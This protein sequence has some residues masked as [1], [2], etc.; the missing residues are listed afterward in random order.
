MVF[1][2]LFNI[3]K[4]REC[5]AFVNST[6]PTWEGPEDVTGSSLHRAFAVTLANEQETAWFQQLAK[7]SHSLVQ[8]SSGMY[9]EEGYYH[10]ILSLNESLN[11]RVLF[12]IADFED[13]SV[14]PL[15]E[16][17]GGVFEETG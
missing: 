13:H 11:E 3:D 10:I 7:V 17:L 9:D 4:G 15:R 1:C 8:F 5:P 2:L 16:I 6:P 14:S 12:G